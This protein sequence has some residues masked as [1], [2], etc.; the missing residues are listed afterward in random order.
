M[1]SGKYEPERLNRFATSSAFPK[2]SMPVA[3]PV[4]QTMCWNFKETFK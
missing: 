3:P 2:F 4:G 1:I